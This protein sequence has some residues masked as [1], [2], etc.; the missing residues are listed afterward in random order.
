M[1]LHPKLL[2][3]RGELGVGI[4][5]D[6]HPLLDDFFW[7]T[8]RNVKFTP[9]GVKKMNGYQSITVTTGTNPVRGMNQL[10]NSSGQNIIWGDVQNLWRWDSST[11]SNLGV[12]FSG[13]IDETVTQPATA[14]S[15]VEWGNW[16]VASNGVD[17]IQVWKGSGLFAPLGGSPPTTAEILVKKDVNILAF[18]T[19]EGDTAYEWCNQD[20]IED[21]IVG[22]DKTAGFNTIRDFDS[23]IIAAVPLGADI[24]VYSIDR[25]VVIT[26]QAPP[27]YFGHTG[28]LKGVG[29]VSKYSIIEV[30]RFHYGVSRKGFF[31]TDGVTH[32][33]LDTEDVRDTFLGNINWN[34]KS[35]INGYHDERNTEVIWYYPSA[36]SQEPDLGVGYNYNQN[37]W[38]FYDFGFTSSQEQRIFDYGVL[39]DVDGGV[40]WSDLSDDADGN[41]LTS[42]IRSKPHPFFEARGSAIRSLEDYFKFIQAVK[43]GLK[44][45][46]GD[47]L[48]LKLGLQDELDE[49]ITWYTYRHINKD[50]EPIY[51]GVSCRWLTIEVGSDRQG[52]AWELHTMSVHGKKVGGNR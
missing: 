48:Y 25:M 44:R 11:V 45:V 33:Y 35:K 24:A 38:T 32:E 51:P 49:P 2:D 36:L 52:D 22:A 3:F 12:S 23:A 21:W 41:V 37:V 43:L 26:T 39:A 30:G 15:F 27:Y 46:S 13:N 18:N 50:V 10:L 9:N 29:A 1:S 17:P 7:E 31:R 16:M 34:Q 47:G 19:D 8:G 6:K 20:N 14:W 5:P 42:Y 28:S 4:S 40:F